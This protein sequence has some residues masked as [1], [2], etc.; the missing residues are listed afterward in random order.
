MV[1]VVHVFVVCEWPVTQ[2][3][4]FDKVKHNWSEAAA[5]ELID[6]GNDNKRDDRIWLKYAI[7]VRFPPLHFTSVWTNNISSRER[8]SEFAVIRFITLD[9]RRHGSI[10]SNSYSHLNQFHFWSNSIAHQNHL[11]FVERRFCL[12]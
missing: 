1:V 6:I 2:I 5:N 9:D 11:V 10:I 7:V 4:R 8:D 12:C 3:Y